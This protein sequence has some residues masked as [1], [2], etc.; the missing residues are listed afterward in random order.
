MFIFN[1]E[2]NNKMLEDQ[3][4]INRLLIYSFT[5]EIK[6]LNTETI[7]LLNEELPQIIIYCNN[8]LT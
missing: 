7:N 5:N 2:T 4:F 3:A 6:Q 1:Q 8:L